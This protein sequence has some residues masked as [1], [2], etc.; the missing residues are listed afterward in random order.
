MEQIFFNS[1][2]SI[3]SALAEVQDKVVTLLVPEIF[4]ENLPKEE[5][6]LLGKKLPY[7][8]RRY[9]KYLCAQKRFNEQGITT[10]YQKNQGALKKLNVRMGT[11]YWALLGTLAHAH[12]VSRCFLFNYMLSLDQAG[13]GDSLVKVLN[14]G[15]PTFHEVYRYIWQLETTHNRVSRLLVFEPN[16]I[17]AYFDSSFPWFKT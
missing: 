3:E 11:G 9:G 8:L 2:E 7:L 12:G 13:V 6:R 15:V 14:R 1:D 4:Y 17:L 16:P 10:L 5:R